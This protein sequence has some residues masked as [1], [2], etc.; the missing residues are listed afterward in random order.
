MPDTSVALVTGGG[1]GIG[2][3]AAL[4]LARHYDR[5]VVTDLSLDAAESVALEIQAKGGDALAVPVDVRDVDSVNSMV[6]RA[7]SGLGKI[8]V[9]VHSAGV[10]GGQRAVLTMSD[11]EWSDVLDVN[12][13]GSFLVTRAVAKHMVPNRSGTI[14]LIASDRGIYGGRNKAHYAASKAGLIACMKSLALELGEFGVTC[15]AINP[16]TTI[17]PGFDAD[18]PVEI[19]EMRVK[20]DPLGRLSTPEDIAEV[21]S[22]LARSG[23]EFITGQLI[24]I[25]MRVA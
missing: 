19:K 23:G 20:S 22:F 24:S 1:S 4:E 2:G 9:L 6:S 5:V 12:L 11:D 3:A 18:A 14:I 15:N 17:T 16:G 7:T 21:I 13:T 10:F 8:D 25:R